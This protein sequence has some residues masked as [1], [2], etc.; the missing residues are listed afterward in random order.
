[1]R[2]LLIFFLLVSQV[3][4][5]KGKEESKLPKPLQEVISKIKGCTCNPKLDK[6]QIQDKIYY[7]L[8][9]SGETCYV[10]PT[11]YDENGNKIDPPIVSA[12]T[13]TY[14]ET[15]WKCKP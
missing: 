6:I 12:V 13:A 9:W 15:V 1:M 10:P 14:L 11:W 4:C 7:K 5:H 2:K 8:N 3:A